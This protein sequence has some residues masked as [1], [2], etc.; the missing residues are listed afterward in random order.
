MTYTV[1]DIQKL[2]AEHKTSDNKK[3]S[4]TFGKN[5]VFLTN[6]SKESGN[7]RWYVKVDQNWFEYIFEVHDCNKGVTIFEEWMYD[8]NSVSV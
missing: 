4:H 3:F 1:D 7:V 2:V 8:T 6:L 5:K